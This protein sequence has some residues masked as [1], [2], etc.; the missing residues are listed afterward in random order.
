MHTWIKFS[1]VVSD[2]QTPIWPRTDSEEP[3]ET[4]SFIP[5]VHHPWR[6][7]NSNSK[8]LSCHFTIQKK[9]KSWKPLHNAIKYKKWYECFFTI[10]KKELFL[11]GGFTPC[12][13]EQP[14]RGMELQEKK[15]QKD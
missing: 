11:K 13:A 12:K 4:T 15:A 2:Y 1:R 9:K 10:I 5:F 14:L 8:S 3:R 6:S 7:K